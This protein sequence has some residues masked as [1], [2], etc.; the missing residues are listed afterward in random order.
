MPARPYN[1]YAG[2]AVLPREVLEQAQ[3]EMTDFKGIGMSLMEISHRSPEYEEIH[4]E[5]Q[6]LF[7]EL[8]LL[9][10]GYRVLFVPGGGSLQFS[11]IPMNFL[12][13][14]KIANYVQT[15]L[16]AEKAIEEAR[17]VGDVYV[18][19]SGKEN[20]YSKMP[21]MNDIQIQSQTDAYLHITSNETVNGTQFHSFPE[22]NDV[23]VFVDMS[24]DILSRPL[25]VSKFDLI[26]AGAQKNLGPSGVTIVIIREEL[27]QYHTSLLPAMLDYSTYVEYN[28]LYNTP[29][30]YSIYMVNL[31]LKW[32]KR[33]GGLCA[34]ENRNKEKAK[35]IYDA[36]DHSDGFYLG[37]AHPDSRSLMNIT[38][39]LQNESLEHIF[40]REAENRQ[41]IGLEGHRSVGHIR[42]S[43]Y[44]ALPYDA[45]QAL[46]EF[47]NDFQK[48]Y[49]R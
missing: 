29:P 37:M 48:R 20:N 11:M 16:W 38:F 34:L 28:S 6:Q 18:S 13:P 3:A 46:A 40:K 26:Y 22:V 21:S 35:L 14:G 24:S 23:P 9:P 27:V 12:K 32:I 8:L 47:M 15:G 39:K 1:F 25:D 7:Q 10:K 36:I 44:N 17:K 49:F 43:V 4:N 2:P 19:Y 31:V 30:V 41:L 42:A 33:N 45:C 5:T